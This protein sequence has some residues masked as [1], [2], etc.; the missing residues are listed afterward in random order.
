LKPENVCLDENFDL[1]LI[2]FGFAACILQDA[3]RA[4]TVSY[5]SPGQ[6]NLEPT[7]Y[8]KDDIF[9]LGMMLYIMVTG[10]PPFQQAKKSDKHY[11]PIA[12]GMHNQFWNEAENR[13]GYQIDDDLK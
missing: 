11:K 8:I 10:L 1:K 6:H 2:D 3:G 9:T 5:W 7:N 12:L 4:G 13:L